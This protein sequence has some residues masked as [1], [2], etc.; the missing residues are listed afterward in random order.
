[1][2]RALRTVALVTAILPA[3]AAAQTPAAPPSQPPAGQKFTLAS[4]LLLSYRAIQRDLLTAAEK[5]SDAD[6]AFRPT[7]ETRPFGQLISHIAISQFGGCAL[8]K[9]EANPKQGEK[10]DAQRT[11]AEQIA[12]LKESTAYC[13]EA[14]KTVSDENVT[15]LV[16]NKTRDN[17]VARGLILSS[18]VTHGNEVYGTMAVY[19]RLKGLVPP[20]TE[21]QTAPRK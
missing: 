18:N 7:P 17:Y 11:K 21:R 5:M 9:G 3:A 19:L 13:D 15:E 14:M 2:Y 6:Y 20:T 1:M 16:H 4:T 8:L 12:L 10:E